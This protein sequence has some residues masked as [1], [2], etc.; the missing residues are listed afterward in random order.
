MHEAGGLMYG[1][2]ANFNA[3]LGIV[4]PGDIG[5][6]F[7]HYNL[8][9]T[10]TTPH[11]GGGPGSGAVGCK[12]FLA[13]YL[14]G[15]RV[16]KR[17]DDGE[18]LPLCHAR[19]VDRA[20]QVLLRQLRHAGARL[21]LYSLAGRCRPATRSARTRCLNANYLRVRAAG[22]LPGGLRPH[23]HARSRAQGPAAR[24]ACRLARSTSPSG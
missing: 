24:S 11:G 23:L 12:Q 8:H 7:M 3:I 20:G 18:A 17:Q 2:G 1:D 13:P 4:R 21:Y 10:F 5:F 6:D 22:H 15:P 16:G 14:P 19:E 9:K